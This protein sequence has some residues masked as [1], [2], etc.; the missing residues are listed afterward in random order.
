MYSLTEAEFDDEFESANDRTRDYMKKKARVFTPR[1]RIEKIPDLE[2]RKEIQQAT[3]A[4]DRKK[5]AYS[6]HEDK[7]IIETFRDEANRGKSTNHL[8]DLLTKKLLCRSFE[9]IKERYRKWIKNFSAEDQDKIVEFCAGK[10]LVVLENYAARRTYSEKKGGYVLTEVVMMEG[11]T[12][13]SSHVMNAGEESSSE[14]KA[15]E[16]EPKED[17]PRFGEA[18]EDSKGGSEMEET[19]KD[20]PKKEH[21]IEVGRGFKSPIG[22]KQIA[23]EA[24]EDSLGELRYVEIDVGEG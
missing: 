19:V 11:N 2:I 1:D 15:G 9:S 5:S 10:E 14:G 22:R 4:A 8:L 23:N 17:S 12:R 13:N 20:T 3:G 24:A 16:G 21:F 6:V 18:G 7:V